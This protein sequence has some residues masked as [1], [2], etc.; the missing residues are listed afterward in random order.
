MVGRGTRSYPGK[1][2]LLLLDF[3]WLTKG[4][5]LCKPATLLGKDASETEKSEIN[6][7]MD[8]GTDVELFDKSR[9]D[10]LR[11]EL[12]ARVGEQEYEF[13]P[14]AEGPDDPLDV[15]ARRFK[16]SRYAPPA[17]PRQVE[18]LIGLGIRR[19]RVSC[20][21]AAFKIFELL[22]TRRSQGLATVKQARR[23]KQL[24]VKA[25][26]RVS[27][28]DAKRLISAFYAGTLREELLSK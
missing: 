4:N 20:K 6:Q 26:W 5:D 19:D 15:D 16:S 24:G 25:P 28:E 23:L 10:S 8:A 18:A 14:L 11:E 21:Y 9:T 3:L 17:T 22:N 7:V 1:A 13:D 2:N 27:F 12:R